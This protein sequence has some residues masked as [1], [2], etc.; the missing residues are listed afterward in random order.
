MTS[1]YFQQGV[2]Y[3]QDEAYDEAIEAFTKALRLTLG[4]LAM[5]L[6]YRGEAYAFKGDFP[7]AMADFN[8]ALRQNAYLTEAYNERGNLRRFM[9]DF[10]GAIEDQSAALTLEPSY[11][12]AYYNRALAYEALNQFEAAEA[13]LSQVIQLNP[14]I[15]VAHEMRGRM[16]V[17]L[18]DLDGAVADLQRYL[19]MG[20]GREYDNHS[21]TQSLIFTLQLRRLVRKVIPFA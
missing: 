4:D 3:L 19:R 13:D 15:A 10:Q 8:E 11:P 12:E 17:N 6:L 20:G 2:A 21:E 16:R 14:G 5:A 9:G 7:R 1:D 18:N